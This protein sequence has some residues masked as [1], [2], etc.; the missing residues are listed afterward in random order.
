MSVLYSSNLAVEADQWR[1]IE[2][3]EADDTFYLKI[4]STMCHI[5]TSNL[6]AYVLVANLTDLNQVSSLTNGLASSSA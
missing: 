1:P 5:V 3:N 2:V 6:G 4:D